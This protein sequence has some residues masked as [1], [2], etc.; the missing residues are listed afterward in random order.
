MKRCLLQCFVSPVMVIV[1]GFILII[2]IF[3][4]VIIHAGVGVGVFVVEVDELD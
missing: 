1:P 2:I 4:M 3:A